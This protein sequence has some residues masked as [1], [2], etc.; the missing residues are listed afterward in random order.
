MGLGADHQRF[1]EGG[2]LLSGID[3]TPG[4]IEHTQT[5]FD[6][7]ELE[8]NLA[9]GDAEHLEF[10]EVKVST[11]LTHVDLLSSFAGQPHEG[12]LLGLARR[13]WPR[14]LLKLFFKRAG[15]FLLVDATKH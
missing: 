8:A 15:L 1:A 4:A 12:A 3:L 11:L 14:T 10:D 2:A 6:Y 7:L 5:R 13:I 9:V